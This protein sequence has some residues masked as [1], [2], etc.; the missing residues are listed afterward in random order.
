MSPHLAGS[1][2]FARMGTIETYQ[3]D[4][5]AM[6]RIY[7]WNVTLRIVEEHPIV[8]GGFVMTHFPAVVNPLLRG[9]GLA[10]LQAPL[11]EHSIYFEVLAEHGWPG[12]AL[13]LMIAGYS[14]RTCSWLV[15]RTRERPD[16]DW[17]NLLGRMGQASLVAYWTAGAFVAQAYLDEYFCV[18]FILEAARRL[19][20]REITSPGGALATAAS[21]HLGV[22][23]LGIGATALVKSDVPSNYAKNRL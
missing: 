20:A 14:W 6:S 3:Q 22:P 1:E 10:Q 12:L 17:A 7:I 13:F 5:S 19:V 2:W 9:T 21:T 4:P 11:A 18:I 23:K 16:L 8:G 15:R